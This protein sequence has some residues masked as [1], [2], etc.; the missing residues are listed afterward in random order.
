VCAHFMSTV[1]TAVKMTDGQ[2]P[3][4]RARAYSKERYQ[5]IHPF[6]PPTS[7][8]LL[9]SDHCPDNIQTFG[10]RSLL[11]GATY[12]SNALLPERLQC[13][14][15]FLNPTGNDL[16]SKCQCQ[17][18]SLNRLKTTPKVCRTS[19]LFH[20]PYNMVHRGCARLVGRHPS[21]IRR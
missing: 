8:V 21:S 7:P 5:I 4:A 16:I 13:A 18:K 9:C 2:T 1:L 3:D 17:S 20:W 12:P 11:H 15:A 6:G 10:Y 14:D 19:Y